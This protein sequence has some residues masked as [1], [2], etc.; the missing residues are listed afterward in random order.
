MKPLART[1]KHL[2]RP[3]STLVVL[4]SLVASAVGFAAPA[5][6]SSCSGSLC[7]YIW[8]T[9]STTT[10]VHTVLT[11]STPTQVYYFAF[12]HNGVSVGNPMHDATFA[13]THS[14]TVTGLHPHNDYTWVADILDPANHAVLSSGPIS[15]LAGHVQ[16]RFDSVTVQYDSDDFGAGEITSYGLAGN[17]SLVLE[18]EREISSGDTATLGNQVVSLVDST[19]IIR[20][21][22][23]LQDDDCN[24]GA[25]CTQGLGPDWGQGSTPELDWATATAW[26]PTANQDGQWHAVAASTVGPLSFTEHVA[27]RVIP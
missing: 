18:P 25:F 1:R 8:F 9:S 3:L 13:L 6:A 10:S 24:W 19:E 23:E 26:L 4:A 27:Y 20:A 5:S 12:D 11:T 17:A 22:V 16:V 14:L 15:T 7:A 21:S 2:R